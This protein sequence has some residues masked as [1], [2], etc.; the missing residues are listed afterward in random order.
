MIGCPISMSHYLQNIQSFL[1]KRFKVLYMILKSEF[2]VKKKEARRIL[3]PRRMLGSGE[4]NVVLVKVDADS[5]GGGE[6]K[7]VL[8]ADTHLEHC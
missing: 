2:G 1:T 5:L 7:T 6:L 3:F 8:A 4:K